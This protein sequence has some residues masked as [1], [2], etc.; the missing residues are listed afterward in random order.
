MPP[1]PPAPRLRPVSPFTVA[2]LR[3]LLLSGWREQE[4]LS[5][6]WDALDFER[7]I[8]TLADTKTGPSV[9]HVGAAALAL[10]TELPRLE[11]SPYVFPGAKP[12]AHLKEIKRLW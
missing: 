5:L 11:R 6:R 3:F 1:A 9:R 7:G 12:G 4:A 10:L 8:A 2:A